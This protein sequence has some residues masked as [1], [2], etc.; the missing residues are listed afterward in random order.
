MK[1]HVKALCPDSLFIQLGK[2][3]ATN[4]PTEVAYGVEENFSELLLDEDK[5]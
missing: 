4:F 1:Q 3:S 2:L 5:D